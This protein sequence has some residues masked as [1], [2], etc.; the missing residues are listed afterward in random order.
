MRKFA[1]LLGLLVL[2]FAGCEK[3]RMVEMKDGTFCVQCRNP[4]DVF[5]DYCYDDNGRLTG[6]SIADEDSACDFMESMV[7]RDDERKAASTVE[8]VIDCERGFIVKG[9]IIYKGDVK[10]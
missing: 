8:R 9:N 3:Y 5:W 4:M 2:V 6:E 10:E 7:R 1:I